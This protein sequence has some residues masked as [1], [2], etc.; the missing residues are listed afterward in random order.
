MTYDFWTHL[1]DVGRTRS[2]CL[3]EE[4]TRA[5]IARYA[6]ASGDV[7]LIHT[8]EPF[9]LAAGHPGAVAHGMLTMGLTGSFVTSLAGHGSVRRFGGRFRAPVLAGD[10][11]DCVL[12]VRSVTRTDGV[13]D[14][15]LDLVTTRTGGTE[16]FTGSA[17]LRHPPLHDPAPDSEGHPA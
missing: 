11:L 10:R 2:A 3:S 15:E 1:P 13:T 14:V 5:D 17:S 4:V 9:A 12:T 6:G 8:D 7:N 16:V